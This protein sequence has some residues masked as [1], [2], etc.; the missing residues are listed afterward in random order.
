MDQGI[1]AGPIDRSVLRLQ[2]SHR[3]EGVWRGDGDKVLSCREHLAMVLG[4]WEVDDR[5]L[6]Y[7]RLAGFYGVH[8]LGGVVLDRPLI[9]ALVER[10]RQ[11]THTFHLRVGEA[12]ITL[13]DVAVLLGLRV[14]GDAV[15]GRGDGNWAQVVHNLLGVLPEIDPFTQQRP[16]AG[17]TLRM[18]WLREIFHTFLLRMQMI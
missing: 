2:D 7:V 15:T 18:S 3:S 10:W 17:S 1:M 4:D 5:I 8:R 13:E 9:T 6:H 14:H 16:M 11:E 12:T